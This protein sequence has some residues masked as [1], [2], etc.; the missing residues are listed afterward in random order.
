MIVQDLNDK[1]VNKHLN[2]LLE[3]LAADQ[4]LDMDTKRYLLESLVSTMDELDEDDTFG[5]EGWRHTYG[6]L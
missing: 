6:F 2:R 3:A 4:D 1:A 5:T